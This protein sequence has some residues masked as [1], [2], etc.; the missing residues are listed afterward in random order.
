MSVALAAVGDASNIGTWSGTPWHCLEAG[1][2]LGVI[3][4]GLRLDTTLPMWRRRRLTW[5]LQ[6]IISCG[7]YGGF[8]YSERFLSE[9]FALDPPAKGE[10][11]VN[12]FQLY[13]SRFFKAHD[14]PLYFYIDQTLLQLFESY[15]EGAAIGPKMAADAIARERS[16]YRA[17]AGVICQSAY[18]AYDVVSRY[19]VPEERVHV[20]LA[21]ANIA[22]EAHMGWS[23]PASKADT[24]LKIVFIGKDWKRKGLDRLVRG[25]RIARE[26]GAAAEVVA[27]GTERALLPAEIANTPA[28]SFV[29]FVDKNTDTKRFIDVVASCDIGCLLSRAEAGGISL[30]EFGLLGL[31]VI[32][33]DV[34]GSPEYVVPGASTLFSSDAPDEAIGSAIYRL[35]TEPELLENQKRIARALR[36]Q[37]S[38]DVALAALGQV[39]NRKVKQ[40]ESET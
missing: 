16:Q 28:V 3:D 23:P 18:A 37:A 20:V 15:S 27:I 5:T 29:G 36:N 17:A 21:G 2:A 40:A 26:R 12:M 8:Q 34:G 22:R 31:P 13:P 4:R 14:G 32:A 1:K 9:L 35:A 11:V 30:R 24:T 19:G 25:L 39:I 33:P 10:T 7:E 6:R 38:W